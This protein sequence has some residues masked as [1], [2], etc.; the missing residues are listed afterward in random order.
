M[1]KHPKR[2]CVHFSCFRKLAFVLCLLVSGCSQVPKLQPIPENCTPSRQEVLSTDPAWT[3]EGKL[4]VRTPEDSSTAYINW[5]QLNQHTYIIELT[6]PLGAGSLKL[7]RPSKSDPI[8]VEHADGTFTSA[9]S[10][11][12]LYRLTGQWI[13]LETLKGWLLAETIKDP[14][15][16]TIESKGWEVAYRRWDTTNSFPMPSLIKGKSLHQSLNI[17]LLVSSWRFPEL[18]FHTL[19]LTP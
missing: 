9:S 18:D 13:S 11:E 8:R 16:I 12:A 19:C 1:T 4:S 7:S 3:I 15:S 14:D 5:Q 17:N 10:A 6:G 2:A